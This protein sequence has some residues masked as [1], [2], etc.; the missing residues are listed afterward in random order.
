MSSIRR[1]RLQAARVAP[2]S[3]KIWSG[4]PW[5]LS[6]CSNAPTTGLAVARHTN[7]AQM[8]KRLWSSSPLA[9]LSSCR[10]CAGATFIDVKLQERS[11][12]TTNTDSGTGSVAA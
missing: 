4:T 8:Q 6:A 3:V 1:E 9:I 2:L 7:R 10:W 5:A 12:T 11:L